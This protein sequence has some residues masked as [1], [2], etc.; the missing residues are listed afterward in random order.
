[1]ACLFAMFAGMF[2]RIAD[3]IL[4][5][6]RPAMFNTAFHGSW[7][8]PSLGDHLPAL[9]HPVLC[10]HVHAWDRVEGLGLAMDRN[11]RGLGHR[12]LGS[13]CFYQPAGHPRVHEHPQRS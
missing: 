7:F 2:P 10:V 9:N 12:A 5:I 8:W 6:A 3:L 4:W 11:G 1:M 13:Y